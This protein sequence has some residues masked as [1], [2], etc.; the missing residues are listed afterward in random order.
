MCKTKGST[1]CLFDVKRNDCHNHIKA[2]NVKFV[3]T[4]CST[5]PDNMSFYIKKQIHLYIWI[6][7]QHNTQ[8]NKKLYASFWHFHVIFLRQAK[9]ILRCHVWFTAI[10][11]H[12]S[13]NTFCHHFRQPNCDILVKIRSNPVFFEMIASF[14]FHGYKLNL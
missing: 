11:G 5:S 9:N 4:C 3:S 10:F 6:L 13:Q 7:T 12:R 14:V 8:T 2:A 1:H